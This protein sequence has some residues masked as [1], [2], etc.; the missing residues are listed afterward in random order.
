MLQRMKPFF[1]FL[2]D[3]QKE[4]KKH[5]RLRNANQS[6]A[7]KEYL[8]QREA[9]EFCCISLRKFRD[10]APKV[11]LVPFMFGGKLV[12]RRD[13]VKK[14]LEEARLGQHIP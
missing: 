8:D 12:Y 14:A 10:I 6:L 4:N 13:D 11:G 5:D 7:G 3:R 1:K 9:A 2:R